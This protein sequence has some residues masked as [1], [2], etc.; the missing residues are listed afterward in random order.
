MENSVITTGR[1]IFMCNVYYVSCIRSNLHEILELCWDI[2]ADCRCH[3]WQLAA[4][5]RKFWPVCSLLCPW[6]FMYHISGIRIIVSFFPV[7]LIFLPL[8]CAT[9]DGASEASAG[10]EVA[11]PG[12]GVEGEILASGQLWCCCCYHICTHL[13]SPGSLGLLPSQQI[14]FFFH[15][16]NAGH[17]SALTGQNPTLDSCTQWHKSHYIT[18]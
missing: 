16:R 2:L 10:A 5:S 6:K 14:G 13:P 11:S 15:S 4:I 12:C 9:S 3:I 18:L 17:G 8:S 7:R 1:V